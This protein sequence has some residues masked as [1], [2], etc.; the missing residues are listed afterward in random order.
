MVAKKKSAM[1]EVLVVLMGAAVVSGFIVATQPEETPSINV[2]VVP[3][4][5]YLDNLTVSCYRCVANNKDPWT[6]TVTLGGMKTVDIYN[7]TDASVAF[8]LKFGLAVPLSSVT[9]CPG[10]Q[11]STLC[12]VSISDALPFTVGL[13]FQ[14]TSVGGVLKVILYYG[15][16]RGLAFTSTSGD[17]ARTVHFES[18]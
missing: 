5:G 10:P 7:T 9:S 2:Q 1:A 4:G 16:G 13:N 18:V 11:T 14:K 15:D 8:S 12:V 3:H 17:I 6:A